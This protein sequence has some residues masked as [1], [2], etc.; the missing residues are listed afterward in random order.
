MNCSAA[1]GLLPLFAGGDLT[2]GRLEDL[3][4]HLPACAECAAELERF[5]EARA[6]LEELRDDVELP[7]RDVRRMWTTVRGEIPLLRVPRR[8]RLLNVL[9]YAAV[10]LIGLSMGYTTMSMAVGLAAAPAPEAAAP[11]VQSPAQ[12]PIEPIKIPGGAEL[13]D[14]GMVRPAVDDP[15]SPSG[16]VRNPGT[17]T[18]T[19]KMLP[20]YDRTNAASQAEINA[21]K[22]KN[23][24]L[25]IRVQQ[26]EKALKELPR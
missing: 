16:V 7:K 9:R 22:Q 13:P 3:R 11:V 12:I 6:L 18:L 19:V 5:G 14:R 10:A 1:R 26:L 8:L 20:V 4:A 24:E 17:N 25:E 15:N 23:L 2:E 21:L